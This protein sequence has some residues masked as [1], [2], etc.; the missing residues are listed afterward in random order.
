MLKILP[1]DYYNRYFV[2]TDDV[3]FIKDIKLFGITIWKL[4][5]HYES[6]G[7]YITKFF[8]HFGK[9]FIYYVKDF[10]VGLNIKKNPYEDFQYR[11]FGGDT[12]FLV[13]NAKQL[14]FLL[15]KMWNYQMGDIVIPFKSSV[16]LEIGNDIDFYINKSNIYFETHMD[17]LGWTIQT[18]KYSFEQLK[19][20]ADKINHEVELK[21]K[22]KKNK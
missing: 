18:D 13:R 12:L 19:E 7:F 10:T 1:K 8:S 5:E 17:G 6:N 14:E 21:F 2:S 4:G 3:D 22:E 15:G 11:T 20:T 9:Q 16:N